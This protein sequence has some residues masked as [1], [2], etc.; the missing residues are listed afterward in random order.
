MKRALSIIL[1]I[2]I[3]SFALAQE[4]KNIIV[5][6]T[7]E[8]SEA[9]SAAVDAFEKAGILFTMERTILRNDTPEMKKALTKVQWKNNELTSKIGLIPGVSVVDAEP[10]NVASI[11]AKAKAEKWNVNVPSVWRRLLAGTGRTYGGHNYYVSS[12]GKDSAD[13]LTPETAWRTLDKVNTTALGYADTVRFRC[14]DVFRGHLEPQSGRPSESVVYMSYGEGVKPIL[15]PSWDASSPEDWVRVGKRLWKCE[16]P[17]RLELGNIIFNHGAKGCAKKVDKPEQLNGK[18][19]RFCWVE[20]DK[21]VYLV[22]R[23][24]P[25]KRFS[26]IELAEKQHVIVEGNG[27]D[28]VYDGLSLRYSAAHGIAGGNVSR[29]VVRNC[30]ISWIGGSTLYYDDEGRGVRYGNGIEFW[31]NASD[32]LVEN[33]RVW[34]CWDAALTNQSNVV[35]AVQKNITYRN[36]E[37]WN[38]EYSYEYWQQG[39]GAHTENIVFENNVCRNAGYGWGHTQRWNPNAGHLMFYDTTAETDGFIISGNTFSKSKN[40][41]IRLFNAWYKSIVMED[42]VWK[43]S[44]FKVLLRYHGRPTHDLVYKYPDH[45]DRIH[46]DSEDEIQ[47]QTVESPLIIRGGHKGRKL[48]L[49]KFCSTR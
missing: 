5:R 13:G 45:L 21:A 24:N 30:D 42:N 39:D 36:N 29:I 16:K 1:A 15:E 28:I 8:D 31:G 27:H 46:L 38:C 40:C 4:Q 34:E 18:D 12:S 41:M 17:S 20:A 11:I 3:A 22:S 9:I 33:C 7:S 19:L 49:E 43:V 10:G 6:F 25:G 48:F 37:V 44:P 14:G 2:F 23:K 26:S 35:G 32:I 47:S